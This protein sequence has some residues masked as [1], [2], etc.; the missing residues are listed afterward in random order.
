MPVK[1]GPLDTPILLLRHVAAIGNP[2]TRI[3]QFVGQRVQHADGQNSP[4]AAVEAGVYGRSDLVAAHLETCMWEDDRAAF[5]K[6][7]RQLEL[8]PCVEEIVDSL[9]A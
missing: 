2:H 1:V 9:R 8:L 6:S 3:L 5:G 7:L 4:C